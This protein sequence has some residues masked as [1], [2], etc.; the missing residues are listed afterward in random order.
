[1]NVTWPNPGEFG[2]NILRT[3][4]SSASRIDSVQRKPL[5]AINSE[6]SILHDNHPEL[7]P[8]ATFAELPFGRS[9]RA[10]LFAMA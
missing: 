8:G 7:Q 5:N 9:F 10:I 3:L 1:M 2:G 6:W 4:A